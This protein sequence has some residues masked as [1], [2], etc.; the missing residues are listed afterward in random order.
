VEQLIADR[1][2]EKTKAY[3]KAIKQIKRFTRKKMHKRFSSLR[4]MSIEGGV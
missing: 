4:V 3:K 1:E 2:N